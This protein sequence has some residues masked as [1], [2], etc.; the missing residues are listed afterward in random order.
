MVEGTAALCSGGGL[1]VG[2]RGSLKTDSAGSITTQS[3]AFKYVM[4]SDTR[5]H[6]IHSDLHFLTLK[7]LIAK[8]FRT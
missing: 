1:P 4:V 3:I 7:P 8:G 5:G 2:G 6:G